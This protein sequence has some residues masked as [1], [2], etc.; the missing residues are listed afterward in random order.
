M[1]S[2][3]EVTVAKIEGAGA[4]D[5]SRVDVDIHLQA[6]LG[7]LLRSQVGHWTQ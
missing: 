2:D 6:V 4:G 7:R 5:Q 1:A 3:T